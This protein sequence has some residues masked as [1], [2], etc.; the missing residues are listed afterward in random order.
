[1]GEFSATELKNYFEAMDK[2]ATAIGAIT[3][4]PK[5]YFLTQS[6]DPSGESLM[7]MEAPL[8]KKA[9]DRIDR[10]I[11]TWRRLAAFLLKL[12]SIEVKPSEITPNF[13]DCHTVQPLLQS[14]IRKT[15]V[16]AG[17]PITTQLRDEGWTEEELAQMEKD[18]DADQGPVEK[19]NMERAKVAL[20]R[21]KSAVSG[22]PEEVQQRILSEKFKLENQPPP[23]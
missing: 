14:Q 2:L 19:V 22:N 20:E 16:E 5:H 23:S 9:Q 8:V 4:T 7:A 15:N 12:S 11:P 13:A 3:R 6:G 1:M 17:I 10:F 21:D 18:R